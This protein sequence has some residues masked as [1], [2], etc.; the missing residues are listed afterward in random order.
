MVFFFLPPFLPPFLPS[1]SSSSSCGG[2][3]GGGGGGDP[4]GGPGG[5]PGGE[6]SM[7]AIACS[8]VADTEKGSLPSTQSHVTVEQLSQK[9]LVHCAGVRL[10]LTATQFGHI[11]LA[12]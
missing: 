10:H 2:G 8:S 3:G 9:R 1:L 6:R 7:F 5:G 4:G 12:Q 11:N